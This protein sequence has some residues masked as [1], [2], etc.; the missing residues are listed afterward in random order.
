MMLLTVLLTPHTLIGV[1]IATRVRHPLWSP[2]LAFLSHS[3]ADMVPHWD[4]FTNLSGRKVSGRQ[5]LAILVDL[6]LGLVVGLFFTFR[7]L[8]LLGDQSLALAIFLSAT[9]ANLPDAFEV[10]HYFL[11]YS[12]GIVAK[13]YEFQHRCHQRAPLPW[14]ALTQ[15]LVMGFCLLFLLG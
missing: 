1:A 7:A 10:P 15:L 9:A 6:G 4:F 12:S 8:W 2:I 3:L 13:V 5:H 11:G 14:G